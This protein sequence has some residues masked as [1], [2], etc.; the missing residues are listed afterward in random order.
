GEFRPLGPGAGG[1][2]FD[3]P[4]GAVVVS[5]RLQLVPRPAAT[6]WKDIKQRLRVRKASEPFALASV[7]FVW[8]NPRGMMARRLIDGGGLRG[9]RLNGAE[10]SAKS[11]NLIINRGGAAPA[12]VLA[13][14]E[15]TRERVRSRF[16]VMLQPEIRMLGFSDASDLAEEPL[17]L[18]ALA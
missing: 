12:D 4:R 17:E 15:M 2:R 8:K 7:G 16:G 14:M 1:Q 18:A 6:V 3:L 9:K 11:S 13:L 10:T 5:C